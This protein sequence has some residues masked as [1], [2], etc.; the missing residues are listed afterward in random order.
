[1]H[2]PILLFLLLICCTARGQDAV[3]IDREDLDLWQAAIQG[4][5]YHNRVLI[6]PQDVSQHFECV[7]R[8][9]S[10]PPQSDRFALAQAIMA[11]DILLDR[12]LKN[13][14]NEQQAIKELPAAWKV[15]NA[16]LFLKTILGRQPGYRDLVDGDPPGGMVGLIDHY[17]KSQTGSYL[18]QMALRQASSEIARLVDRQY[19]AMLGPN[20]SK[21][22]L[23]LVIDQTQDEVG[24]YAPGRKGSRLRVGATMAR[25]S[26]TGTQPLE[27]VMVV[28]HAEMRPIDAN[29]AAT[30][31]MVRGINE[32]FDP[33][34]QRNVDADKYLVATQLMHAAPQGSIAYV[35]R[36]EPGDVIYASLYLHG[37]FWDVKEARVSV[38]ATSGAVLDQVLMTGGAH[39]DL[40]A[41]SEERKRDDAART[42]KTTGAVFKPIPLH[43]R[44][45][46]TLKPVTDGGSATFE[47]CVPSQQ[48]FTSIGKS[49][50][51]TTQPIVAIAQSSTHYAAAGIKRDV[52]EGLLLIPKTAVARSVTVDERSEEQ[53]AEA[54]ENEAQA[55]ERR[56]EEAFRKRISKLSP[57]RQIQETMKRNNEKLKQS[58]A[59]KK[60]A[61]KPKTGKSNSK[62]G[63]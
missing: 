22:P 14:G 18:N 54:K 60:P 15:T 52:G 46:L 17:R 38:Y 5:F 2:S 24:V 61:D 6:A 37:S 50:P 45:E 53:L 43:E 9:L 40:N 12:F 58:L 20:V 56:E 31:A 3:S 44:L 59:P 27:H 51:A 4:K 19:R 33:G 48:S 10:R 29:N 34:S 16:S 41:S 36:L 49:A 32:A 47:V 42:P 21:R 57:E 28:T 7:N 13:L 62:S 1:M 30:R 23:P 11:Q 39:N 55:R 63:K 8:S 25:I 35:K 26:Y